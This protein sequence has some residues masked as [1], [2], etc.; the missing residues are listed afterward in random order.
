[1]LEFNEHRLDILLELL[2]VCS[3]LTHASSSFDEL[4]LSG[5]ESV[6][7]CLVDAGDCGMALLD[8]PINGGV[9]ARSETTVTFACL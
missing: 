2:L 5:G 9:S 4:G 7:F 3:C 8:P 1:M 6:I